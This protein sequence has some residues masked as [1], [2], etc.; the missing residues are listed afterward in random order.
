LI[1]KV[2]S[3]V[4]LISLAIFLIYF[5]KSNNLLSPQ[6]LLDF[7]PENMLLALAFFLL[8]YS[9][10]PITI[11]LP[12]MGIQVAGGIIFSPGIAVGLTLFGLFICTT[13]AYFYGYFLGRDGVEKMV[14]KYIKNKGLIEKEK[15]HH[16]VTLLMF[17]FIG[18]LPMD[19]IG[20]LYGS[21]KMVFYKY[22]L[23][24]VFGLLPANLISTFIG[25]S[26]SSLSPKLFLISIGSKIILVGATLVIYRK[27]F[28]K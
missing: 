7:T 16:L 1:K 14:S 28:R 2:V 4:I 10:K 18:F 15:D 5:A 9:V 22:S 6:G 20:M 26:A 23:A 13:I 12:I 3:I 17:R 24:S 25:I 19:I 27:Q 21:R 11:F 8:L